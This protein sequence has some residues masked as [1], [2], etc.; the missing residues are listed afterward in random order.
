M[1]RSL[2]LA[3]VVLLLPTLVRN[4]SIAPYLYHVDST[5]QKHHVGTASFD[6]QRRLLYIFEPLVDDDRPLVHVWKVGE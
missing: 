5:Q 4:Q 6:R 3:A 1:K 2:V